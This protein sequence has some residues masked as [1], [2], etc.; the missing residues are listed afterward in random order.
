MAYLSG[1]QRYRPGGAQCTRYPIR[2][3][4][5]AHTSIA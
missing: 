5:Y 3:R 4:A 1:V 2:E